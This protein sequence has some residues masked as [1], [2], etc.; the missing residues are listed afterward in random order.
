MTITYIHTTRW[1]LTE[2]VSTIN[3]QSDT[4]KI[5]TTIVNGN[6]LKSINLD[7]HGKN[8]NKEKKRKK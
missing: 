4:Y 7:S 6:L 8:K 2:L 1:S 5:L 3:N